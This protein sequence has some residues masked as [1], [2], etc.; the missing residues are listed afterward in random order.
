MFARILLIVS[1]LAIPSLC[2]G[3]ETDD[4][5]PISVPEGKPLAID[6]AMS[7]GE[8]DGAVVE[9]LSD[10]SEVLLMHS[11]GNLY[12]AIRA[13]TPDMI[14]GNVF[15]EHGDEIAILHSSGALGT[16]H[17]QKEGDR[18]Q[19]TQG[20]DWRCRRTDNSEAAQA[21]RAAFLEK[22]HWL[23]VNSRMG[24]PNELEYQIE[25]KED[26][27]RLAANFIRTSNTNE[28]IPWPDNLDDDCIKPTPGGMPEQM[29]FSPE[30][31]AAIRLS[32]S[33]K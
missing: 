16:A 10:G 5:S 17:F 2:S 24:T 15:I 22:E 14:V 18:W 6:G 32:S 28:K 25:L 8:W 27:L 11:E 20:F 30:R 7:P 19:K 29:I 3:L 12:L 21:E 9:I 31:W 1:V 23:A 26:T 13:N 33:K 4:P